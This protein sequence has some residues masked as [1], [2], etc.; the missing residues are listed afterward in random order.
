MQS[1]RFGLGLSKTRGPAPSDPYGVLR[2][3]DDTVGIRTGHAT[4]Y[5]EYSLGVTRWPNNGSLAALCAP[6]A[7]TTLHD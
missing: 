4:K 7:R 5:W 2:L 3:L 1:H 6:R